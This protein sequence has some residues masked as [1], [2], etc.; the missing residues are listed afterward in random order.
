VNL[1]KGDILLFKG[2]SYISKAIQFV[3]RSPYSHSACYVGDGYVIEADWGGVIYARLDGKYHKAE[4]DVYRHK[5]ASKLELATAVEYMRMKENCGYDY[6]GL[7]GILKSMVFLQPDNP[8][9]K[10]DRFWCQELIMDGYLATVLKVDCPKNTSRCA[11]R[12]TAEDKNF[13]K[14]K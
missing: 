3:T 6:L 8:W 5:T 14:V 2:Q 7:V 13:Y 1:K 10:N 9:D 12:D 4:Y 11:P